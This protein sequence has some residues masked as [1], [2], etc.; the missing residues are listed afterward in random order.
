[1]EWI[2]I[3]DRLPEFNVKVLC[4]DMS[5]TY[6]AYRQEESE[7][8]EHWSISVAFRGTCS[9]FFIHFPECW[10]STLCDTQNCSYLG[11]TGRIYFW[12]PLPE[13]PKEK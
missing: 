2:S 9:L 4:C 8:N 13:P 10:N 11:C 7:Y 12:M 5:Q 6:I 3:K 1:M